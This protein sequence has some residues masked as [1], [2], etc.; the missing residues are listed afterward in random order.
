MVYC[1]L[2][3]GQKVRSHKLFMQIELE[4]YSDLEAE[5]H[6]RPQH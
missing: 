4:V 5:M 6:L 2:H 3:C 1:G